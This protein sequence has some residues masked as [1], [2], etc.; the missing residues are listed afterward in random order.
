M[1]EALTQ[2]TEELARSR[3]DYSALFQNFKQSRILFEERDLSSKAQLQRTQRE[4]KELEGALQQ[5]TCELNGLRSE[6]STL[7]QNFEESCTL[8]EERDKV[9][10]ASIHQINDQ[11]EVSKR[12]VQEQKNIMKT[13]R[14]TQ[15]DFSNDLQKF[16]Q[17]TKFFELREMAVIEKLD[18]ASKVNSTLKD[19]LNLKNKLLMKQSVD[20]DMLNS[21]ITNEMVAKNDYERIISER[22]NFKRLLESETVSLQTHHNVKE[23]YADLR[24]RVEGSMVTVDEYGLIAFQLEVLKKKLENEYVKRADYAQLQEKYYGV[25]DEKCGLNAKI[26][27][28]TSEKANATRALSDAEE[29]MIVVQGELQ[30]LQRDLLAF[31]AGEELRIEI[32][33]IEKERMLCLERDQVAQRN[34]LTIDSIR[35]ERYATDLMESSFKSMEDEIITINLKA[36]DDLLELREIHAIELLK[37]VEGHNTMLAAEIT[38]SAN[39]KQE[40]HAQHSLEIVEIYERHTNHVTSLLAERDKSRIATDMNHQIQLAAIHSSN[41]ISKDFLITKHTEDL[42]AIKIKNIAAMEE[43]KRALQIDYNRNLH[44]DLTQLREV[45]NKE[46]KDY[47]SQLLKS[48]EALKLEGNRAESSKSDLLR[49]ENDYKIAFSKV[50]KLYNDEIIK[51]IQSN[52]ESLLWQQQAE[53]AQDHLILQQNTMRSLLLDKEKMIEDN[54]TLKMTAEN[55]ENDSKVLRNQLEDVK[56]AVLES[57]SLTLSRSGL[58]LHSTSTTPNNNNTNNYNSNDNSNSNSKIF[59]GTEGKYQQSDNIITVS[60]NSSNLHKPT[61]STN[62]KSYTRSSRPNINKIAKNVLCTS[63]SFDMNRIE[64]KKIKNNFI[65]PIQAAINRKNNLAATMSSST[66]LSLSQQQV[67]KHRIKQRNAS[68]DLNLIRKSIDVKK[69]T[70]DIYSNPRLSYQVENI[71][72]QSQSSCDFSP[73]HQQDMYEYNCYKDFMM[74]RNKEEFERRM[75]EESNGKQNLW[76]EKPIQSEYFYRPTVPSDRV[77][78][79]AID[80]TIIT[81]S[82]I[83]SAISSYSPITPASVMVETLPKPIPISIQIPTFTIVPIPDI[84]NTAYSSNSSLPLAANLTSLTSEPES[85]ERRAISNMIPDLTPQQINS[86]QGIPSLVY[87]PVIVPSPQSSGSILTRAPSSSL[88]LMDRLIST[89]RYCSPNEKGADKSLF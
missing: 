61:I 65:T 14:A 58:P 69:K 9:S 75:I 56:D 67:E 71:L 59:S 1:E 54:Q 28:L 87:S 84:S 33:A 31:R 62:S 46:L 5:L 60:N 74:E 10:R 8:F 78:T 25:V 79:D 48:E 13:Q 70:E 35:K 85:V 21:I 18:S 80:T 51:K 20:I 73:S 42:E 4:N 43:M 63:K 30:D 38:K 17:A 3:A 24:Y 55:Y 22:D 53:I 88:E 77:G 32:A 66:N 12:K 64:D 6:Y 76:N 36:Q 29:K 15:R 82:M 19:E 26:E 40:I 83:R 44:E 7:H 89:V 39:A 50:E 27:V 52:S 37:V 47:N 72:N 49:V 41:Q 2:I 68:K 34:L 23:K 11:Y 16:E 57:M 45:F 86:I 81:P